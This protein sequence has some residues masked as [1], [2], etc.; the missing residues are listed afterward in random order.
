[1]D[2]KLIEKIKGATFL[3]NSLHEYAIAL[4][5]FVVS[6][7]LIKYI[8]VLFSKVLNKRMQRTKNSALIV[9]NNTVRSSIIPIAIAISFSLA[10]EPLEIELGTKELSSKVATVVLSVLIII[11]LNK[12]VRN[13]FN[14]Y[15]VSVH[16]IP[17]SIVTI[18]Q[19]LI[20]ILGLL[21]ILANI[22]Y[23]VTS[24]VTGLGVGG[25]AIALASQSILGDAFNYFIIL[26][27]KPFVKGDFIKIDNL[28]G[29][30]IEIGLKAV[31]LRSLTGELIYI[32][33]TKALSATIQNYNDLERRR[34]EISFGVEYSTPYDKL[35]QISNIVKEIVNSTEIVDFDR[36]YFSEFGDSSLNFQLIYYVVSSSILEYAEKIEEI[37]MKIMA[38]LTKINV[39]FAFPTRTLYI[40]QD[41]ASSPFVNK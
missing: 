7:L 24:F 40:A 1:M 16:N 41:K 13:I 18:I 8:E 39:G 34:A 14:Q 22:G 3:G 21:F 37:N 25:V 11:F 6:F 12:L 36:V 33:N 15:S 5:I 27:D 20:W 29:T 31:Q 30:V 4:V 32:S 9:I 38:E 17:S 28:S 35:Q 19:V 26:F 10:L 23:D 2:N